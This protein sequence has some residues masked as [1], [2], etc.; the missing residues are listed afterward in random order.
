[1][2][3]FGPSGLS[4]LERDVIQMRGVETVIVL[5]GINDIGQTLAS[6][7]EVIGGL[8]QEVKDLKHAGL[9]VFLGTLTPAGG[10]ILPVLR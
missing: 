3:P 1:V 6:A 7:P 8:K 9:R 10:T 4:R 5:E 2:P